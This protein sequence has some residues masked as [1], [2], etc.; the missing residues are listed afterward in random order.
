MYFNSLN[1]EFNVEIKIFLDSVK[2]Q[3]LRCRYHQ[4]L[5]VYFYPP[6]VVQ[7]QPP[8]IILN[9]ILPPSFRFTLRALIGTSHINLLSIVRY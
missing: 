6:T 2:I 3:K 7:S 9:T 8:K 1:L 5:L 4:L